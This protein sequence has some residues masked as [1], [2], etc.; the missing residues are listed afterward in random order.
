MNFCVGD[1]DDGEDGAKVDGC[2]DVRC[3]GDDDD[4][5]GTYET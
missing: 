3:C 2:G 5:H 4:D 1:G